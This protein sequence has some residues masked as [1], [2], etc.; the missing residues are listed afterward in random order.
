[1]HILFT[2][3]SIPDTVDVDEPT[4]DEEQA[5]PASAKPTTRMK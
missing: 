3:H 2:H 4:D 1:L 5:E